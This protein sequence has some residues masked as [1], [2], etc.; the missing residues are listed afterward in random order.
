MCMRAEYI[1]GLTGPS[2]PM[3]AV[4]EGT[5]LSLAIY[6]GP[7]VRSTPFPPWPMFDDGERSGLI[8]A[9][10]QGQWWR[11]GGSQVVDFERE[12]A[13]FHAAEAALAVTNG[14]HALQLALEL[15]GIGRGDEV[16]VP[17]FTFAAT[18]VAVQLAGAVPVPVDVDPDTY[19]LDPALTAAAVT[20]R[21]R[22]M[23]PVHLAGHVA[24]MPSLLA[25]AADRRITVIQDAAH[26]HGAQFDGR[27]IGEYDT[28]SCFSFQNGK[29]MTAGEGGALLLRSAASY[30]E[31]FVR[32]S[33]GRP[34]HDRVYEHRTASSNYRMNEF[35][36]AVLRNQLRRLPEQLR[37]REERWRVLEQLLREIP[38][39]VPQGR[40]ERCDV[41]SRYMAMF[42]L[43]PQVYAGMKRD[44]V[45][46]ALVAEGVP[47]F[48]NYPPL[49]RL[50][51]FWPEERDHAA[52]RA[53]AEACPNSERLGE[54]GIWLH[55][56]VLLGTVQ[57][58]DDVVAAL[59]KVLT[60]LRE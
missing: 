16:I 3:K 10:E 34:M 32:H 50:A 33:C 8:E 29:L 46:E 27:T 31:A 47:A 39:I 35:S 19:C 58:L 23:I 49:Y 26:A 48:V 52:E 2:S 28:I 38:G 9:L 55:H 30:E 21:T 18:S 44:L 11:L 7:P 40:D 24:D 43:S 59:E 60:G 56:R 22:A 36:A 20:P 54:W 13:A 17:A 45:V 57:D 15:E 25:V 51:A 4:V 1:L 53:F 14:T 37:L 12:F 6:G 41:H 5:K 42:T